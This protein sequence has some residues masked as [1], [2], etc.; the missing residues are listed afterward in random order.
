ML[1]NQA[2]YDLTLCSHI[3]NSTHVNSDQIRCKHTICALAL[4]QIGVR[5]FVHN[6]NLYQVKGEIHLL[7]N[8]QRSHICEQNDKIKWVLLRNSMMMAEFP[9]GLSMI[10]GRKAAP[11]AHLTCVYAHIDVYEYICKYMF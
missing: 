5:T 1:T 10:L 6:T 2:F 7:L 3:Q 8:I 11:L 9:L 4:S